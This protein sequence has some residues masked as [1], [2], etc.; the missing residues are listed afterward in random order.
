M[1]SKESG[2]ESGMEY[3]FGEQIIW[4]A[5]LEFKKPKA[6]RGARGLP[7]PKRGRVGRLINFRPPIT[8][9]FSISQE[10]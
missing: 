5:Q 7:M 2:E 3:P 6:G 8:S 1:T 9:V 4:H 10:D